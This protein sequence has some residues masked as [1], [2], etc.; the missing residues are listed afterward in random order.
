M[1]VRT[2]PPMQSRTLLTTRVLGRVGAPGDSCSHFID[3]K[4]RSQG[5]TRKSVL[6]PD[7]I[8]CFPHECF[9]KLRLFLS[10]LPKE[11]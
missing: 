8:S 1:D 5:G 4:S 3:R 7:T 10:S 9:Y 11:V 2:S 6:V